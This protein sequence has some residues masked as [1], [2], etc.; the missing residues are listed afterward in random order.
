M[1]AGRPG[2]ARPII[3]QLNTQ[4]VELQLERWESPVWIAE[5]LDAL[6]QCL[7]SGEPPDEDITRANEL[8]KRICTMDVTKALVYR[9]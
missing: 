1:K 4:I 3:E 6:Y 7:I 9:K 8:F 2:L 5:V